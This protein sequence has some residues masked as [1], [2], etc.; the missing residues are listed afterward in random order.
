[1]KRFFLCCL[2][3]ALMPISYA[4]DLGSFEISKQAYQ[5]PYQIAF[6]PFDNTIAPIVTQLLTSASLNTTYQN[7]IAN[8]FASARSQW[9]LAGFHYVVTGNLSPNGNRLAV[10]YELTDVKTGQILGGRQ[11]LLI[12][13]N[14]SALTHASH[15]IASKIQELLTGKKSDF[16]SKIAYVEETGDPRTKISS[17][18]VMDADGQ[19]T[20]T[21]LSVQGSIFGPT[22]S[23][24]G[25]TLAYAVQHP[26]GLPVIYVQNLAGGQRLV[27][28]FKGNNL[29]ASFSPDGSRLL[30]SG[31]HEGNDPAIYE[32]NLGSTQPTKLTFM[33]GAENSPSYA[34]DGRSFVF[35]ADNGSRTPQLYR[36]HMGARQPVRLASGMAANPKISPDG[37]KI[38]YVAG[39]TL[40]VTGTSGGGMQSITATPIHES[41]TFSPNS[42]Y[43][44]YA[45]PRGLTIRH[46]AT[47]QSFTK[48]TQGR[49]REP[50]WSLR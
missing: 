41:A 11:T 7:P 40:V 32:L 4:E 14:Q 44:V 21:L 23:P 3:L 24:D 36:Y 10:A 8:D 1:M 47:G 37:Q 6:V 38:A 29:G 45:T 16:V 15:V 39:S 12:D 28:P 22:W 25:Q 27:T 49:V 2:A 9:Q 48:P 34:P 35:T 50:A 46:L 5:N 42:S 30:F 13:N 33:S 17:L 20:Q 43:L 31:S 26:K 19:N 18:K